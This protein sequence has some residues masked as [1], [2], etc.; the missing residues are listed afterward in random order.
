M[1]FLLL[2]LIALNSFAGEKIDFILNELDR[3]HS[4]VIIF[5]LDDTLF[6]SSS[7]TKIIFENFLNESPTVDKYPK[8]SL[9]LAKI[10][11]D[12]IEYSIVETLNNA[13]IYN[14]D[15]IYKVK[16]FWSQRFFS[17]AF[18]MKDSPIRGA[19]RYVNKAYE[20][21]AKIVYLT[22]R[23]HT[24]RK[25]SLKSLKK[26]GFPIDGEKAILITKP[27][28]RIQDIVFKREAFK[29][30]EKMGEVIA[31]FENEPEN[32]NAMSDYFGTGSTAVFLDTKH[33]P[34]DVSPYEYS[35]RIKN[36]HE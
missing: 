3:G 15:F 21:G 35:I 23:D 26:N 29:T 7:R 28:S 20:R 9:R 27:N 5:D 30:I 2:L 14:K 25:G 1:K 34:T 22:G 24:M 32:L 6:D 12:Q 10:K 33:S 8:Q 4:K 31:H 11:E 13:G 18:V 19:V 36:F 17:N 16:T